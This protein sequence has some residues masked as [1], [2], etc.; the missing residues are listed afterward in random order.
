LK[1]RIAFM[2]GFIMRGPHQELMSKVCRSD[3]AGATVRNN[4]RTGIKWLEKRVISAGKGNGEN[5]TERGENKEEY[6]LGAPPV[7]ASEA[8]EA[9]RIGVPGHTLMMRLAY[10]G[11]AYAGFARQ[12]ELATVQG[13]LERALST[14]FARP[15]ETVCAGRTDAGVHARDQAITF[16][17]APTE[18]EGRNFARLVRSMNAL[19]GDDIAVHTCEE[20]PF[21]FS[22][23]FD[24]VSREY[25]YRIFVGDQPPLFLRHHAWWCPSVDVLDIEAMHRAASHLIGEH[26]FKSFCR[27]ASACLGPTARFVETLE[28]FPETQMGE[29]HIVVRVVGNAFLHAMVRTIVGTLVEVG[30]HR[31]SA[32]WTHDV[33]AACDRRAAGPT[34]PACGLTLWQVVY[35]V[36]S[37]VENRGKLG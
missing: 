10:D 32:D 22:A 35:P 28:V 29:E 30:A 24:A 31:R 9:S 27:T 26:D 8:T 21:G 37:T 3:G 5:V 15:V 18:L 12:P 36:A 17:V 19:T 34:A 11:A 25:R 23:R 33:L 13:E 14:I 2:L 7:W 4:R 20:R 1:E 16:D 6:A